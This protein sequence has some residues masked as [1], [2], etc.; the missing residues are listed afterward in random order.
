MVEH[1][2]KMDRSTAP[3]GEIPDNNTA[4]GIV[5]KAAELWMATAFC[6]AGTRYTMLFLTIGLLSGGAGSVAS[7]S[8]EGLSTQVPGLLLSASAKLATKEGREE[9][10]AASGERTANRTPSAPNS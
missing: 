1:D 7:A 3:N 8:K 5:K 2:L 9:P 10:S 6:R 4:W